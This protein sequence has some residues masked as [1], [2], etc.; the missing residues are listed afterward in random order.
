MLQKVK[1]K[2]RKERII[3]ANDESNC[4]H[5]A[6]LETVLN[7]C[8]SFFYDICCFPYRMCV[9]CPFFFFII[10]S[11]KICFFVQCKGALFQSKIDSY[12]RSSIRK[13]IPSLFRDL[14]PLYKDASKVCNAM[15]SIDWCTPPV[16]VRDGD[17]VSIV[18]SKRSSRTLLINSPQ[19]CANT[20]DSLPI[21]RKV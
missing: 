20:H 7:S 9:E 11:F 2:K 5:P 17:D 8:R 6:R 18:S 12:M 3:T 15:S 19:T 14:K 16:G 13:A 4:F 1:K 10:F 21:C